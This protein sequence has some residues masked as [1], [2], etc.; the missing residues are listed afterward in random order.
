MSTNLEKI[1]EAPASRR[2]RQSVWLLPF[3]I[4]LGFALLFALLFR[5]RLLPATAVNVRPA[6][7]IEERSSV[8]PTATESNTGGR[9]LFQA[10]GWIEPDP[11][12]MR[13]TALTDGVVDEVHVL[14]GQLVKR[15]DL[16]AT[17]IDIDALLERDNMAASLD[18][19]KAMFDAHC[20]GTQVSLH[21]MEIEK[22]GLEADRADA[23]EAS[24]KLRRIES[25]P[26]NAVPETERIAARFD[27][28]RKAAAVIAR[29]ARI[30]EIA[31]DLNRIAYEILAI[32]SKI[33]MEEIKL[34]QAELALSRTRI[35]A[36]SD[37]RVLE[38][39]AAPGQKKMI[40]MDDMESATIAMLYDPSRLQVRVDVPLA[41]ASGLSVGQHANI[42]CNLLPDQVFKGEVTRITGAADL[43]RNTLQ[44]KVR[45]LDPDEKLRPEMLSRVE[46]LDTGISTTT[47]AVEGRHSVA[48][49]VPEQA[50]REDIVWLCD[51][52]TNRAIRREV[53]VSSTVRE[54][55]LRIEEGILPGE[56]I[57]LDPPATLQPNQRLKPNHVFSK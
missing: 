38:L 3:A 13:A 4:L 55:L 48:V 41:D 36:P 25:L 30:G 23:D 8:S 45:I 22:A 49:Y 28:T 12:P 57:I 42:R 34:V 51:P 40:G 17:L 7:G 35:H 46:F 15:G 29:E 9:L 44:A 31:Q 21:Q 24:D 26:P 2:K 50:L 33:K 6:L 56:W 1:T 27:N 20:V 54:N 43:Q 37:A 16:L 32:Q 39:F 53:S 10:S 52:D 18:E 19:T 11:L 47:E 5:D 14:E